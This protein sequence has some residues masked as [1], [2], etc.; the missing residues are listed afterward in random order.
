MITRDATF[1]SQLSYLDFH[2]MKRRAIY[3][4]APR[5]SSENDTKL[6]KNESSTKKTFFSGQYDDVLVDTANGSSE[7][8]HGDNNARSYRGNSSQR[9]DNPVKVE[10]VNTPSTNNCRYL[11]VVVV[12]YR[13]RSNHLHRFLQEIA[14]ELK[15]YMPKTKIVIIEQSENSLFNR[16]ALLNIGFKEFEC[17]TKFFITHDVDI[18]PSVHTIKTVYTQND[19]DI[20]RIKSGHRESLGGVVKLK[21]DVVFDMNGFP[22]YIWGWGI[23]DRALYYRAYLRGVHVTENKDHSSFNTFQHH[24]DARRYVGYARNVSKM[25]TKPCIDKLNQIQR[26]QMLMSS[27]VNNVRYTVIEQTFVDEDI[28]IIKVDLDNVTIPSMLISLDDL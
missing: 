13:N 4:P 8:I 20:L 28:E 10:G 22:N 9:L 24:T 15:K 1:I 7:T 5:P 23:E 2:Q 19:S 26:E 17:K 14:P 3:Q 12:P 27:G 16:G 18:I 6:M 11:D 25:W 21:H